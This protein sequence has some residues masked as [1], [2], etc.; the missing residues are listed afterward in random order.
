[1]SAGWRLDEGRGVADL[2]VESGDVLSLL[3][4]ALSSRLADDHDREL[5][6]ALLARLAEG[7]AETAKAEVRGR[8]RTALREAE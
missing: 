6:R 1:M 2:P 7:G 5:L 3:Y 8:L 4:D